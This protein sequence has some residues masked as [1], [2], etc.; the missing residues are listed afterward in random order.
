MAFCIAFSGHSAATSL[1]V[2]FLY[3][4]RDYVQQ[5]HTVTKTKAHVHRGMSRNAHPDKQFSYIIKD[6]QISYIIN[7]AVVALWQAT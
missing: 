7:V 5:I 6:R 3:C 1:W 4:Y 2:L